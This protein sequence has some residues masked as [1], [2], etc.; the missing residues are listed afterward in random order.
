[1]WLYVPGGPMVKTL[2]FQDKWCRFQPWS[3]NWYP[4]CNLAR[5]KKKKKKVTHY[6]LQRWSSSDFPFCMPSLQGN[7]DALSL[8]GVG[9]CFLL[10]NQDRFLIPEEGHPV[11]SAAGSQNAI[12]PPQGSS[13]IFALGTQPLCK[14]KSKL[15]R[16]ERKC[17]ETTR[18]VPAETHAEVPANL[19]SQPADW[20]EISQ[21]FPIPQSHS[22]TLFPSPKGQPF[23]SF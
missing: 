13:E 18:R 19:Q 23:T 7:D 12:Q 10:L 14:M 4:T 20:M 6:I 21:V 5:S 15:V 8:W 1:M 17:R 3:G 9:V 2:S 22:H 16:M 11:T